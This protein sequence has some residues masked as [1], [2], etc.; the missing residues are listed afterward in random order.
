M[1]REIFYQAY[2]IEI[3][4]FVFNSFGVNGFVLYDETG[5]CILVDTAC[6]SDNE[7]AQLDSFITSRGLTPKMLVNTHLHVDHVLGN[8]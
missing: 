4:K 6:V 1:A 8:N 7:K 2:M 3:K 5:E